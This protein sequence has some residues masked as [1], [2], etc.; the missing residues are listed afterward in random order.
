[1]NWSPYGGPGTTLTTRVR[2][3]HRASF[4]MLPWRNVGASGVPGHVAFRARP[5]VALPRKV[6]VTTAIPIAIFWTAV[7]P[8]RSRAMSRMIL[9]PVRLREHRDTADLLPS[10]RVRQP[11]SP[12]PKIQPLDHRCLIGE[13]SWNEFRTLP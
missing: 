11:R 4:G 2:S 1:M 7:G 9:A 12:T 8:D 6:R 3:V 13:I 5:W 10:V